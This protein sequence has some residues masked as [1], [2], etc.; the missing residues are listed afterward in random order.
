MSSNTFLVIPFMATFGE[1]SRSI[2]GECR[3]MVSA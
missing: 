1:E 3:G 2:A